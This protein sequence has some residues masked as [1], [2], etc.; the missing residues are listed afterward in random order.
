MTQFRK[1]LALAVLAAGLMAS[2]AQAADTRIALVVKSLGN[3]FFDAANKGAQE[4]AKELGG[5]EI[6]YTGPTTTTAEGQIEV[7]NSLISQKVDAI[8]ISANDPDAVVPVLKKAMQRGI[9]VISFD[10]GVSPEGRILQLNPS[11]NALIGETC[12][13][14][15]ADVLPEGKGKI[16]ILSATATS[17]NQNIWIEEMK[18]AM[19]KF[20]GLELVTTVYGDDLS[21]KSYRETQALLKSHPD[22]KVIVAPTSVGIVAAAQAVKDAG[23][24]GEVFVTGLGLPSEMAGAI[25][26]GASKSFAIWNPIDLGYSA[27]M[28]ANDLVKEDLDKVEAGQ[29]LKAGRM[30]EIEIG[31]GAEAAM[32][33]PFTY[34]ASNIDEFAKIF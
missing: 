3:G 19:P 34:D 20:P 13:K 27:A 6:I 11:S 28:L 17:T 25:K 32:S 23:K 29:R 7:L 24:I 31:E 22:V 2:V 14:L 30:G 33:V 16:A 9:K 4:A 18:K 21:D 15:A 5:V 10:S 1:S 8:A 26:S 12:L